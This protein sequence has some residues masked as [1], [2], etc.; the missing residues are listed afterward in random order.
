MKSKLTKIKNILFEKETKDEVITEEAPITQTEEVKE[1]TKDVKFLEVKTNEET[2]L[3]VKS[4]TLETDSEV[5][6]LNEDKEEAVTDGEY[7][8]EDGKQILVVENGKIKEI[9]EIKEVQES[10]QTEEE[11]PEKDI[12]T[13]INELKDLVTKLT[14]TIDTVQKEQLKFSE[15]FETYKKQPAG[16]AV[17]V[18]KTGFSLDREET[19]TK[20]RARQEQIIDFMNRQYKDKQTIKN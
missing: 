4:E 15:D 14:E 19:Q 9:R 7:T 5:F 2:V 12:D 6:L 13:K 8:L 18:A 1:E 3:R 10:E 17:K 11:T 16:K 20:K